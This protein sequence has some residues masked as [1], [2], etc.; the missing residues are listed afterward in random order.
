MNIF[1]L[2]RDI[3]K[4][5]LTVPFGGRAAVSHEAGLGVSLSRAGQRYLGHFPASFAAPAY[6]LATPH[7]L[8]YAVGRSK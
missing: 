7:K 4:Q 5:C 6:G 1:L 8:T 2:Q 3:T